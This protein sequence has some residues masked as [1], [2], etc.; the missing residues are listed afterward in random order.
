MVETVRPLVVG[1]EAD[2][3]RR[4]VVGVGTPG[5][6]SR[7]TGLMKNANSTVLNGRPF[8]RD[9]AD[10]AR[11]RGAGR[12]RRQLLRALGGDR[13]QRRR[14]PARVRRDPGHRRGRRHRLR[15]PRADRR[16]RDRRR[17]GAQRDAVAQRA[18]TCPRPRCYCGRR[19][20]IETYLSG[21]GSPPIT[22]HASNRRALDARTI[23]ALA[24]AGDA[25]ARA[26]MA[27]YCT[28]ARA[29]RSRR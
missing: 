3:G 4:G 9:L 7:A 6:V 11:P 24:R 19:R 1:L 12:E 25:A 18:P 23:A 21:P 8:P 5:A 15:R 20:C 17:V 2:L 22:P 28:P 26:T 14:P 27:R 16:E 13:R 29:R 10:R